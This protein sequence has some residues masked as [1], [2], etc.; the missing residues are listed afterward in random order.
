MSGGR[1]RA[2]GLGRQIHE[3]LV[4]GRSFNPATHSEQDRRDAL[5]EVPVCLEVSR[6][7]LGSGTEP[8]SGR[9][10]LPDPYSEGA[11]LG[12]RRGNDPRGVPGGANDERE[13]RER[14]VESSLDRDEERVEVDV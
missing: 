8:S 9:H 7:E 14:G 5:A 12:A 13:A 10:G 6:S 3:S 4:G 11:G 2:A 1:R